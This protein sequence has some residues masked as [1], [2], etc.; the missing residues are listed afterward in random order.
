LIKTESIDVNSADY[1]YTY[2][3]NQLDQ[4][5]VLT[6]LTYDK[7]GNTTRDGLRN[8][9]IAYNILNLPKTVSK[10]TDNI[11]VLVVLIF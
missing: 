6:A 1:K 2:K 9:S 8:V 7:N 5:N 11:F 4:I 3:G 10:G